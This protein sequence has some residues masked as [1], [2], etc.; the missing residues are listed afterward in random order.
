MSLQVRP[1]QPTDR[2]AWD[3]FVEKH[4]HGTVLHL[5]AWGRC[6]AATF[7]YGDRSLVAEDNGE[8]RAILPLFLV[9]SLLQGRVLVSSPFAVYGGVLALDDAAR[10]AIGARVRG[11]GRELRVKHI[12]I[13][14]AWEE[15]RLGFHPIDRYATF[16]QA[17]KPQDG[18]SLQAELPKKTRN[19][20]RKALKSAFSSRL[21]RDL[22]TFYALLSDTYHRLGTPVFSRGHFQRLLDEF[23]PHADA[24]EILVDDKVVA[25]SF[26]FLWRGEMHTYYAASDQNSLNLAPNNFL[27][28]D[29]ILWAG[30]NGC[31]TFDFGRSKYD[32]GNMEFKRHWCT[33]M[34]PL[35]YEI[36]L[37]ERKE[38]PDF[39]PKN[40][41]FSLAIRAWR[42]LPLPLTKVLGPML[43]KMFP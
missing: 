19:M 40:E 41:N 9:E 24:R 12:E 15:Q 28:Y 43:V 31:H 39:T 6:M 16:T 23:G 33:V 36:L 14:N 4:P 18:E 2:A 29:H 25:V 10:D 32:T 21:T 30:E 3:A 20:V 27:Y 38:L 35:P 13:R 42:K 26:N 17:V 1:F 8:L 7:G 37:V 34:R 5:S 22:D 11:L